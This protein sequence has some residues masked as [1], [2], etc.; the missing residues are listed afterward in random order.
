M[1]K[2]IHKVD[3]TCMQKKEIPAEFQHNIEDIRVAR[4]VDCILHRLWELCDYNSV[5][6]RL[7]FSW[8]ANKQDN[9]QA[10]AARGDKRFTILTRS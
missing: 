8:L 7:Q 6:L 4:L 9:F 5:G 1:T 10:D 2:S 3:V